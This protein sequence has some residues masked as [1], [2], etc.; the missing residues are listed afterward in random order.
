MDILS[1]KFLPWFAKLSDDEDM[2]FIF[3]EDGATCHTGGYITWWKNS[4]SIRRFDFWPAQSPDLNPIEHLWSCLERLIHHK[5]ASLKKVE[6]LKAALEDA[7]GN[8]HVNLA[9]PLVG[10]IKDRCQAVIDAKGGPTKY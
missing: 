7:W 1:G 2:D 9:E 10:N 3:Q 4:H 5:R 6:D 8:I